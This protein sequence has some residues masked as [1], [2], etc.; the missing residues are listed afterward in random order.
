MRGNNC[1]ML[2]SENVSCLFVV[3]WF[4]ETLC[5]TDLQLWQ[6]G[7]CKSGTYW[8]A[9]NFYL[10][11]ILLFQY[12]IYSTHLFI[13]I[14]TLQRT[15]S[16]NLLKRT[17]SWTTELIRLKQLAL[18]SLFLSRESHSKCRGQLLR[19]CDAAQLRYSKLKNSLLAEE[20]RE[21]TI[22]MLTD[23]ILHGIANANAI[24][25]GAWRKRMKGRYWWQRWAG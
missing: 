6:T 5:Y 14:K 1:C 22:L 4:W 21:Y 13:H 15:L 9:L 20:W 25:A 2:N 3:G 18:A 7:G 16:I 12:N 24:S 8:N 10:C 19:M 11:T 23:S 17:P